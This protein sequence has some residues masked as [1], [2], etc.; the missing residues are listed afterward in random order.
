ML[1]L[2]YIPTHGKVSTLWAQHYF[3]MS[4]PLGNV[5]SEIFDPSPNKSIADKRNDAVRLAIANNAKTLF[6]VG[7]DVHIPGDTLNLMLKRWREGAKA[8]T[9][10]YWT[11][12]AVPE[13]YIYRGY[14]DGPYWDWKAGEYFEIDW[15]GCDCLLL[16]VEM[17]KTIP[18]PWFNLE[19]DMRYAS[20]RGTGEDKLPPWYQS[21]R[22]EDLYFFSKLKDAGVKLMCDAAI[23]CL[24]EDRDTGRLYG[25]TDDM[26][27]KSRNAPTTSG[28]LIADIGCGHTTNPL[29]VN[30]TLHR[31]DSDESCKPDFRCDVRSIPADSNV[32][33]LAIASHVLEH[34]ELKDVIPALIEWGRI[35]KPGGT[36]IVKVPNLAYATRAF[37]ADKSYVHDPRWP[38]PYEL[39]MVYGSQDGAAMY[40]KSGFTISIMRS[41][42]AQAFG[43]DFDITVEG[44]Q[45]DGEIPTEIT[46]TA[47]KKV[48]TEPLKP[49]ADSFASA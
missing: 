2:I 5:A 47:N 29:Y 34:L 26:P 31:F 10:V 24:H 9:G 30:N 6:F 39:L 23:Q 1:C 17:L 18:E 14:M 48:E 7:D 15:S 49:V 35:V 43:N 36:L 27:Q 33:D 21:C 19:Y 45:P 12:T 38:H 46:L 13:P 44:T 8:V 16:D 25:L 3:Y 11:K 32:Y 20:Q 42:A 22:T 40:H 28:L 37:I 41:Y 4:K